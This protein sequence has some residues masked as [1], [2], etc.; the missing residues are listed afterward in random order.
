MPHQSGEAEPHP[1]SSRTRL[2]M[3]TLTKETDTRNIRVTSFFLA[4]ALGALL[5]A[6]N[7]S[8][9]TKP[10]FWAE[11]CSIWFCT[12]LADGPIS[13]LM[14]YYPRGCRFEL[15]INFATAL[16]SVFRLE[17]APFVTAS[18]A[19]LFFLLTFYIILANPSI[20]L[21]TFPSRIFAALSVLLCCY[22]MGKI[23]LSTAV[24]QPTQGVCVLAILFIDYS[25]F[26]K[27]V[28]WPPVLVGICGLSGLYACFLTPMAWYK[29]YIARTKQDVVNAIVLLL[30]MLVQLALLLSSSDKSYVAHQ[31]GF[32]GLE[33]PLN[34]I[35]GFVIQPFLMRSLGLDKAFVEGIHY[36]WG[37]GALCALAL[38]VVY[39]IRRNEDIDSNV[40]LL[41][42][43]VFSA[44]AISF[45][46]PKPMPD[47]RYAS[48]P[49]T[50]VF[51][52]LISNLRPFSRP[53]ISGSGKRLLALFAQ[54]L[55]VLL[56]LSGLYTGL[57]QH[58]KP[59]H[60]A[61]RKVPFWI[62]EVRRFKK[63][64]HY[65]ITVYPAPRWK[66]DLFKPIRRTRVFAGKEAVIDDI[67]PYLDFSQLTQVTPT[68]VDR[69]YLT[70]TTVELEF[71]V[72][73]EGIYQL[74]GLTQAIDGDHDSW[75]LR[76]DWAKGGSPGS[77]RRDVVWYMPISSDWVWTKAPEEWHLSP[78]EYRL[79]L[80]PREPTPLAA[81][82]ILKVGPSKTPEIVQTE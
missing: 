29:A 27:T 17:V 12:A 3:P 19:F 44:I 39:F 6:K 75:F 11:E 79:R 9:L 65:L 61:Y 35:Y 58:F 47:G 16:A 7:P 76:M 32:F 62:D 26:K 8:T 22:S 34:T 51:F 66:V 49:R 31:R 38:F 21:K 2:A 74:E 37:W 43:F 70:S 14:Y 63:Y 78:G 82:R 33:T 77:G 1:E 10:R 25:K 40:L 42:A 52:F 60:K 48:L 13:A 72:E 30:T 41:I 54:A 55:V 81:I 68:T 59:F 23:F 80:V 53:S 56:L 71:V 45:S 67:M 57:E 50:I 24:L 4:S 15:T 46:I 20:L 64:D 69:R 18:V 73:E 28:F 5:L 36:A